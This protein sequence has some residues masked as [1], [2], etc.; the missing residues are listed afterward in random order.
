MNR[1]TIL[2]GTNNRKHR[3]VRLPK[4]KWVRSVTAADPLSAVAGRALRARLKLVGFYAP[5]AARHADV[6][7]EYVHQLRV[8]TRRAAAALDTFDELVPE[9][10]AEKLRKSLRRLRR[11][12][13]EARDLDV[14]RTRLVE[15]GPLSRDALAPV[16]DRIARRRDQAQK[17]LI[18][19]H[20]RARRD[21]F[22][23]R[24]KRLL[25]R[26]AWRADGPEPTLGEAAPGLLRPSAEEF[27]RCLVVGPA[28]VAALHQMRIAVKRLRYSIELLANGFDRELQQDVYPAVEDLA[29]R[30]G[31][32]NDHATARALLERWRSKHPE[33]PQL[34]TLVAYEAEQLE[35]S[36]RS[37]M[38]S[39]TQR[40]ASCLEQ[41]LRAFVAER[42]D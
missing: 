8:V 20:E 32:L 19:A 27:F 1:S 29:V 14:L 15:Q 16:L 24:T 28:D 39:W 37:L 21:G 35:L 41:R 25:R 22:K 33:I 34:E 2:T 5:L 6:H 7:I 13:G 10:R 11:A 23:R 36:C 38:Q 12:A 31:Q 26:V 18:R 40:R 3:A 9:R 4:A 42:P 17:Q 30:L